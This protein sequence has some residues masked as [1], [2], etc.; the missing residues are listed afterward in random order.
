MTGIAI[1]AGGLSSRMG[2]AK[3]N[4]PLNTGGKETTF[5]KHLCEEFSG[6]ENRFISVNAN[7]KY[8]VEGYETVTDEYEEI[9]PLGG[10]CSVLKRSGTEAVVFVACD[11]PKLSKRAVEYLIEHWDGSNVCI[12]VVD[13]KRQPLAGIY[14]KAC[15]P[16]IENMIESGTYKL[17]VLLEKTNGQMVDMSEFRDEFTNINTI[18]DYIKLSSNP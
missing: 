15:I 1:L 16:Y 9:G 7:Q 11:M 8:E 10:I 5:L 12:A 2:K 6:F 4:L 14:T 17:G 13:G 3:E 18:E